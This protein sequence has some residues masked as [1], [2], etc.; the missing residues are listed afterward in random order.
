[1]GVQVRARKALLAVALIVAL[2]A[3]TD[4]DRPSSDPS[5]SDT[6]ASAPEAPLTEITVPCAQ[7]AEATQKI[8]D[9]Q[10]ALYSGSGGSAAIDDLVAELTALQEGAPPDIQTAL[11]DMA[12]A[13]RDAAELLENPTPDNKAKL[14]D[15]SSKLAADGQKITAYITSKCG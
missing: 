4:D 3:C 5:S 13:F 1:M 7:F 6:P 11:T 2:S 9:A 8:T 10:A 15:L 14:V 12:A